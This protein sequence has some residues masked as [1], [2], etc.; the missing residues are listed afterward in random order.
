[1]KGEKIQLP[2]TQLIDN[3][4][5]VDGSGSPARRTS[6]R[7]MDDRIWEI[8]DLPLQKRTRLRRK[9]PGAGARLH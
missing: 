1:M 2:Q 4:Q 5:L 6:V 8:G 3:V 7:L 9:R